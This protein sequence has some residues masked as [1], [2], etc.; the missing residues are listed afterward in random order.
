MADNPGGRTETCKAFGM[1]IEIERRGKGAPLILLPDEEGLTREAPVVDELARSYEVVIVS[2]PGFGTSERPAWIGSVDDVSYI[3]LDV[4][5]ALKIS[6]ATLMGFSL[7]GW[8]AAE[9]ASKTCER[10]GRLVLVDPYGIKVSGPLDRDIQDIWYLPPEKVLALKYA[11]PEKGR[12]D[13]TQMPESALEIVAR[14][15]ESFAR[16]CWTPYMHNPNL[17]RRL[18]RIPVPTLVAWGA[19]DGIVTADY[20]RAFAAEIPNATFEAIDGAGHFPHIEQPQAFMKC[21]S[22]FLADARSAA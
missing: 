22:G 13:Y 4:L 19:K 12:I 9:M 16:F 20:G 10:L 6:N 17:R 14:N 8:I 21:I 2:P 5:D 7:G 15:R 18:H 3:L 1:D 11:D